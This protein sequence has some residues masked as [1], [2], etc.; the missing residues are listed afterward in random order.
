MGISSRVL[1]CIHV[2]T[3]VR[4]VRLIQN[5]DRFRLPFVAVSRRLRSYSLNRGSR[6]AKRAVELLASDKLVE[7]NETIGPRW[8]T[9][10]R[11][12]RVG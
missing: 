1:N 2:T 5:N 8:S 12:S 7:G 6:T 10:A 4:F 11:C 3:L 9:T